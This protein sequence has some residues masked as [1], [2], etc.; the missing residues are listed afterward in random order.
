MIGDWGKRLSEHKIVIAMLIDLYEAFDCLPHKLLLAKLSAYGLSNDTCNLLTSYLSYRKQRVKFSKFRS[1]WSEIINGVPQGSILAP[2]LFNVFINDIFYAI[3]N[4]YTYADD[5]VLSCS[6][7]YLHE[8][9]ASPE[10]STCTALI[11]LFW[12]QSDASKSEQIP[13]NCVWPQ[14]K[15]DDICFD[16]NDNKVEA[17]K[18]VKQ[19]GVYIDENLSL[20]EHIFTYV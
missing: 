18:C 5:D 11:I 3:E 19:L 9:T 17:T 2:L 15:D 20:D 6:G 8:V 12:K 10:S 16:I 7:D 14:T 4:M 13:S 1:S